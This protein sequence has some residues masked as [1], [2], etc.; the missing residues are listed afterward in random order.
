MA[1]IKFDITGDNSNV[2]NAFRGVQDGVRRTQQVVES[3]GKSIED[4]FDKIKSLAN[5]AFVGFTAKEFITTLANVR[6]EFQ[7]LEVAFNTMLGSKEKANALMGQLVELA[8]TT[9]FDLKGVASGAKQLLAYGLEAEK[10]TDTMRRLG[11][12]AAGLGLQIGDLAWLYGT[13]LTQGRMY[14]EDLNQFTGR[15]IPM[16][17][18]LAKQFGVAESEVKQ[19][20]TDGKVGFPQVEQAIKNLTDEGGKFGGLMEAQSHTIVGQISNIKDSIDMAFNE[21]GQQ[22]EGLINASLSVVSFLVEHWR[23]V[24]DAIVTAAGAVG[25][26][27]AQMLAVSAINTATANLGY[28]AEI[29]QLQKIVPL[30]QQAAS[31]DLQEAVANGSLTQAK[32]EHIA[33]M[34]EEAAAYV[35]ELQQKAAAAQAS[36][37]EATAIAAQRALELEAAEDKVSACQQAYDAALQL[38]DAT[39]IATAEENLNIAAVERNTAAK[40]LQTAR[41]NVAT[42]SKAAETA[43]TEANTAAQALNTSKTAADTAAKGVWA[44]VVTL[45]KRVQDAWN[46]SMLSSPLFWIAAA[47]AGATYAVYKLVTAISD[48]EEATS[49]ADE[50][51]EKFN[52]ATQ[53][54]Q[55]E[56]DRLFDALRNAKQGTSEY[57]AAKDAILDKYGDYLNGLN[58]EIATLQD[59]EGAYKAVT[60]AARESARARAVE[61]ATTEAQSEYGKNYAKTAGK[62]R[63]ALVKNAGKATAS[64]LMKQVQKDLKAT[65]KVAADTR[66]KIGDA[67]TGD[68]SYGSSKAWITGLER[69]EKEL[70]NTYDRINDLFQKEETPKSQSSIAKEIDAATKKVKTLRKELSD[71]RSGKLKVAAGDTVEKVINEKTKE[72]QSA[73]RTLETLTGNKTNGNTSSG[74]GLRSTGGSDAEEKRKRAQKQLNNELL[75]LQRKNQDDEIALMREGTEKK[76]AEIDN[77][78]KKRIAEIEKQEAEFKEKN[79]EAGA[80]GLTGGLTK[81]QLTALQEAR[82]NA[83][84]EQ[85]QQVQETIKEE[86]DARVTSL[87]NYLKEYGDYEQKRLAITEEYNKKIAD[88]TSQVEKTSLQAELEKT[89]SEL[90]FNEFKENFNWEDI[91]GNLGDLT[92]KQLEGIRAQLRTLLADGSLGV[93]EYKTVVEQIGKV[94]EAIISEQDKL[95]DTFGL[96]LPMAEERRKLE[97]DVAEANARQNELLVEQQE[98]LNGIE[99]KRQDITTALQNAGLDINASDVNIGNQDAILS[100]LEG[101]FGSDSD[102]YKNVSKSFDELNKSERDLN[103]TTQKLDKAQADATSAQSKLNKFISDFGNKL[104][105]VNEIMSLVS[106]NMQ[107]LPDL[108]S[109]LGVDMDSA[110]GKGITDLADASQSA[111]SA[112]QDAMSGNFVGAL[113]NGIGAV[114]GVLSGFNNILGLGI[115]QGNAKETMERIDRLTESNDY[116]RTSIDNLTEKM[117]EAAGG[118]AI[119]YYEE[120]LKAQERMNENY[121]DILDSSMRYTGAH[122]SNAYYWNLDDNSLRQ[123]N[124]LLGTSLTNSWDDFSKLTAEQMDEIRTHLPDIWEEMINQGKYGGDRFRDA[125]EDYAD[126]A[127][128]VEELTEQINENLTQTSFDSL[129][130]NFLDTLMDMDAD[131]QD[132]ADDFNEM[133]QR[134]LLNF[135]MGDMLDDQ[136]KEWYNS[137]AE[138]IS[139]NNGEL[140]QGDIENLRNDWHGIADEWLNMRDTISQIT[141]YTGE[142]S[143]STQ[144]SASSKGFATTTQDSI[145]ELNGRFTAIYEADLKIIDIFFDAVTTMSAITSVATD[146]NTELRNILNQQVLT[147][148]HLEDIAK[149][150]KPILELGGKLDKIVANT[151]KL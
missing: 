138:T 67:L 14:T 144:Q 96:I 22:S 131:A 86:N 145:D 119:D 51:L 74:R 57:Q 65:G 141:G 68:F 92:L 13:T 76:L 38:G 9:P 11:D 3:S 150:T 100:Q 60:A 89:L 28:D 44:S 36:Y 23:L 33:A 135:A 58:K 16:I 79:K 90:D 91:F 4:V 127:G 82:D 133:M 10:V 143:S 1:G 70:T 54:E 93:D 40:Q 109:Q 41:N 105:A 85:R 71:L 116:L 117:D 45:C 111:T 123:V 98:L 126:Q 103:N 66:K 80:T 29:A 97:L 27:K 107:S 50:A 84:K 63:D 88:A 118:R 37:N 83:A 56:I 21:M 19:L 128:K 104:Q 121:Q 120:A 114:K 46:A 42:A 110:F 75:A 94:N 108:F 102:I 5:T 106:S 49:K 149:Y 34:R 124:A 8:A 142:S 129:R 7:Q 25:L 87:Q 31:T 99:T 113:S 132:F 122:H 147:N 35:T 136:L 12:I 115:G 95:K 151:N 64:K 125:W 39:K 134:A 72:L 20:V 140:S 148:S 32:A 48:Q 30:K 139:N 73:Q 146:C 55:A 112:M 77:D 52:A 78:Y 61:S 59:V 101:I 15:G 6:G 130:S 2:L 62:L 53:S 81:E 69:N 26:Y 24:G 17:A 18:E 47:I 43:A 137:L